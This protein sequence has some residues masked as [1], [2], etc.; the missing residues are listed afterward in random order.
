MRK[1]EIVLSI[2]KDTV[3]CNENKEIVNWLNKKRNMITSSNLSTKIRIIKLFDE[4]EIRD[5]GIN[6]AIIRIATLFLAE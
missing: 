5:V 4:K 2:V 3:T 6:V 1:L